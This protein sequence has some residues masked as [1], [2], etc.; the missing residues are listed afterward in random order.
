MDLG[1]YLAHLVLVD[2]PPQHP[3]G[4]FAFSR[5]NGQNTTHFARR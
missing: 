3:K 1:Q 2:N 4:D 5:N